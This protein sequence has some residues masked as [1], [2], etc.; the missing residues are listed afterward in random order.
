MTGRH[1]TVLRRW[2][3]SN[4]TKPTHLEVLETQVPDT[5][6]APLLFVHGLAHGAWCFSEHWQGAAALRGYSSYAISLRGHG[7]SGGGQ[8]LGRTLLRDYVHDVLQVVSTMPTVPVIV[9]HSLGAL[10]VQR[11][12]QRY[13]AR[14]GV[15]LTPVPAGGIPHSIIDGVRRKPLALAATLAGRTLRLAEDD[16]FAQLPADEAARYVSRLGPESPWAQFAM[17]RPERLGPVTSPVLVVGAED[18]RLIAG[19]DVTRA[20]AALNVPLTWVPGGH[21]V[22]LDGQWEVVLNTVLDWI[23]GSCLPGSPPLPGAGL[24]PAL[25]L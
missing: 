16:L 14:A 20:A 24:V 7:G 21:D 13:P 17:M 6:R 22:M 23:D 19:A 11:V 3:W 4:P 2:E 18:D 10:V 25:E 12:L 15:L 1:R 8:R 5:D 9:G